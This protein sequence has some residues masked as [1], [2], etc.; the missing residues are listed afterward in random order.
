MQRFGK[1]ILSIGVIFALCYGKG[2]AQEQNIVTGIVVDKYD[3]PIPGV[4]LSTRSGRHSENLAV[5]GV[6]GTFAISTTQKTKKLTAR[7]VGFNSLNVAIKPEM[8]IE[9]KK[10]YRTNTNHILFS[11][12]TA[13]TDVQHI[14]PAYGAMFGWCKEGGIYIKGVATSHFYRNL[15]YKHV[16]Y[17]YESDGGSDWWHTGKRDTSYASVTGGIMIKLGKP[18]FI[19]VGAGYAWKDV[20]LCPMTGKSDYI[21]STTGSYKSF[22]I[23]AGLVFNFSGF[24]V[25]AGTIYTP[26]FGFTGSFGI[27]FCL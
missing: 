4:L 5:T 1:F 3:N 7:Y 11:V 19:Y 22:A 12:Q 10:G 27:G 24:A 20:L 17:T 14:Q 6:D 23:D 13:I 9:L 16:D 25:T 21:H 26:N 8:Q 15:S 2:Y 18:M